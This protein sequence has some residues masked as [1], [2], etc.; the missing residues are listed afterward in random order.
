MAIKAKATDPI[1][2]VPSFERPKSEQE[3]VEQ[4]M[5]LKLPYEVDPDK[6]SEWEAKERPKYSSE[7]WLREFKLTPVG[8]KDS[9][10]V[11]GDYKTELHELTLGYEKNFAIFRG[12]D[13]GAVQP[14]VEFFQVVNG[15]W[16]N[17]IDEIAPMNTFL[18]DLVTRVQ[19]HCKINYPGA[20]F[21]DWVDASGR[22][23]KDDGRPSIKVMQDRGLQPRY[24][25]NLDIE[26]SVRALH[27]QL[28]ILVGGRPRLCIDPKKMPGLAAAL[29]GGY[30]RDKKGKII[31]DGQHDHY[32][33]AARYA[34]QGI[35]GIYDRK[36]NIQYEKAK[37][38]RYRGNWDSAQSHNRSL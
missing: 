36:L 29:R 22:N 18:D 35:V 26:D 6:D 30:K 37:N 10:P 16:I 25:A 21:H 38:Y 12:W 2:V 19:M 3:R 7:D 28:T 1:I 9:Y 23:K 24:N 31:K 33:D 5:V 34:H 32:V 11:F 13:F 14:V 4:L 27:H 20:L 17:G 15:V 8:H